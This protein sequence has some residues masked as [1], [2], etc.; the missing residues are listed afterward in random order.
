MER[1]LHPD[2]LVALKSDDSLLAVVEKTSGDVDTHEPHPGRSEPEPITHD[3]TIKK[4]VF[5]KFMKDGVPPKGIV[6]VRWQH[7]PSAQLIPESKLVLLDRS[8]LMGDVVKRNVRNAMSGVVINTFTKCTLQPMCDLSLNNSSHAPHLKGLLPQSDAI[9][10]SIRQS[11]P[12]PL[13]DVPASELKYAEELNE[14]EL[15]IYK[16]WI[17]RIIAVNNNIIIRLHDNCVVEIVEDHAEHADGAVDNF[18]VGDVAS[19]KK[20][21]LRNGRWIFGQY[22]PNTV[23]IGT[24][25]QTSNVT[26]EITWLQRRIGCSE[27]EREPPGYLERDEVE[28]SDFRVYSKMRRSPSN[29]AGSTSETV[30]NSEIDARLGLRVRFKDL[31]GACVKY[32]GSTGHG[33]LPRIDRNDTLGYDLNVFDVIKFQTDVT[34][35]WQDLSVTKERSIDLVPDTGIDDQHAAWPGEIAHTLDLQPVPDMP[36]I[37]QPGRVGVIQSVNAADRMANIL[38]CPGACLQYSE[39]VEDSPGTRSLL[40][41]VVGFPGTEQE[42]VS[43]YDVEAPG[44]M[45]VRRGDIVL[46]THPRWTHNQTT[47]TSTDVDWL[48]EIV[49][50]RLDG[51]LTVRLG[52]APEVKDVNLR[53]EDVVVAIRSDGTDEGDQWDDDDDDMDEDALEIWARGSNDSGVEDSDESGEEESESEE[54]ELDVRYEDENGD[55]L[56]EE[57][58]D[59]ENWESANEDDDI[60]MVDASSQTP[61]TSHSATPPDTSKPDDLSI[62]PSSPPELYLVLEGSPPSSHHFAAQS[63]ATNSTHMK[64]VQ[65]SIKSY[66]PP[67]LSQ[68]VCTSVLGK[69]VLISSES[70][71]SDQQTRLTLMIRS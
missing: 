30:S 61:P 28:S 64:R 7:T 46:F 71:S 67:T 47:T 16:D 33:K 31:P 52:A 8:L 6:L 24:V 43:L 54:D 65:R 57:D 37:T 36:G 45:N 4:P 10:S 9:S 55:P 14:E 32:D 66:A 26:V 13:V 38:W 17:G 69:A 29:A 20:G 18:Y 19:T 41:G 22:N 51:T 35:Q 62:L 49:D 5:N 59:D 58:V 60:E 44:A 11:R 15:V 1:P 3:K 23:P 27:H 34:V 70:C 42:E 63:S 25:M 39:D 50:T 12:A 21:H 68:T 48:G 40:T 2:D 53:R 56:D